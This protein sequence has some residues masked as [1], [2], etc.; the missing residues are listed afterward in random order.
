[1]KTMTKTHQVMVTVEANAIRVTPDTLVMTSL[2]EL[3]WVGSNAKKFTI[4][5][6]GT[7]PFAESKLT[8]EKATAK[9]QPTR[10]GRY[11]YTV[12]SV[13]NPAILLDP[14]VVVDAPPTPPPGP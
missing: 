4:E 8:H 7:G 2:D 9:Q 3:Q 5:F 14:T 12:I 11:K 1:M 6:E 13:E 10:T